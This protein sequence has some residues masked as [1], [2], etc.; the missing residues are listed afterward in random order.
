M[1]ADIPQLPSGEQAGDAE[2]RP[3]GGEGADAIA[4]LQH[5]HRRVAPASRGGALGI[6]INPEDAAQEVHDPVVGDARAGVQ[7]ALAVSIAGEGRVGYLD[8]EDRRGGMRIEV[9]LDSPANDRDVRLGFGD[10]IEGD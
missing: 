4:G 8:D 9:V 1:D 2:T 6:A 5:A 7:T 10:V 3:R